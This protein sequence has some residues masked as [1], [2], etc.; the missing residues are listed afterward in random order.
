MRAASASKGNGSQLN[1]PIA[2][3]PGAEPVRL[4]FGGMRTRGE[5]GEC[6]SGNRGFIGQQRWV[7]H[8]VVDD[9]R[10]V[11]RPR[12][13]SV[14]EALVYH[15][16]EVCA[17]LRGINAWCA[18][19]CLGKGCSEHEASRPD[20]PQFRNRR[21]VACYDN[22]LASLYLTKHGCGLI[23]KLAL[24]NNA[25]HRASVAYVALCSMLI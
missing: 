23:A 2:I 20:G 8:V 3:G 5:L 12:V 16:V 6:N 4:V 7:D 14:I 1:S 19:R 17:K 25:V 24:R 9:H 21:A 22:R 10:R 15:C 11:E 18:G 13:G